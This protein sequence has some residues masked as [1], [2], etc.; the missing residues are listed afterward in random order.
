MKLD[1]IFHDFLK[2]SVNL[3]QSRIDTLKTRVSTIENFIRQ[4]NYEPA[5]RRFSEQGS[6]AHKTIIKPSSPNGEFDADLVVYINEVAGWEARDY[7]LN[8]RA[9]FR[10]S[11]TYHDISSIKSRC[12]TIDYAGDFHLDIVPII[13]IKSADGTDTFWVCNRINNELEQTDGEGYAKWWRDQNAIVGGNDL[14]K[15]TRLLKYLRDSKNTFSAKSVLLTTLIGTR[16]QSHEGSEEFNGTAT[17]LKTIAGRMDDWL[18]ARPILPMVENPAFK[19]ESFTRNWDQAKYENFRNRIHTYREWIDDA[20]DESNRDESIAKWRRIF[21]DDFGK[22]AVVKRAT[23]AMNEA[24]STLASGRDIVATVIAFGQTALARMPKWLPHVVKP[25]EPIQ[26]QFD[27]IINA[28]ERR[29][30]GG[31]IIRT[32]NSG[33]LLK[34][35]SGVEFQALQRNGLPFPMKDYTI[36]WQVVNTDVEATAANA[37]RGEFY[38]SDTHGYRYESTKFRGVHWV[39]AYAIGR[40]N[41]TIQGISERFFVVVE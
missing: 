29:V 32:L 27:I 33:E 17:S 41:G 16:I 34:K 21:G 4:S 15:A 39:Q 26:I 40:R 8:L 14:I 5:I 12:V 10:S 25:K 13:V 7:I 19:G 30:K 31:S 37:L 3:N 18:Q 6:W 35:N 23:D 36:S 24:V 28:K 20:F 38:S 2:T 22:G 1:K 9:I 11:L